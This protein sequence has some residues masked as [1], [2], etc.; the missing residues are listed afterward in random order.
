MQ[1]CCGLLDSKVS[2]MAYLIVL[3]NITLL[4]FEPLQ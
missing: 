2:M 1:A 3:G 4:C